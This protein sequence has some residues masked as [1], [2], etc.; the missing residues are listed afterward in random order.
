MFAVKAAAQDVSMREIFSASWL[1]VGLTLLGMFIM[2]VFPEIVT[3]LPN[4]A[5]SLAQ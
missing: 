5:N 2:T 4:L 1:F 3:F